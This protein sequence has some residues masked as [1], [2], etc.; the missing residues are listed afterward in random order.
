MY[1]ISDQINEQEYD[2]LQ[3]RKLHKTDAFEVLSISLEK[4][5]V[6]P[7][8]TS[9]R[10]V[11]LIVL[12]GEIDFH[13]NGESFIIREKQHFNFGANTPHWVMANKDS[14]FLII[15]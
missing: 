4:G 12:N 9:P 2:Q 7:E 5:S 8:H 13:I 1:Q 10:D 3:I 11:L 15:R 6:F 14:M